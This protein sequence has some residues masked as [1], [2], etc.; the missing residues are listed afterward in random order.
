[1]PFL[2][3][4]SAWLFTWLPSGFTG[5]ELVLND[6]ALEKTR[7][8]GTSI[9]SSYSIR[10]V[11]VYSHDVESWSYQRQCMLIRG[12]TRRQPSGSHQGLCNSK[13]TPLRCCRFQF[14]S[15]TWTSFCAKYKLGAKEMLWRQEIL[16]VWESRMCGRRRWR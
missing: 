9:P 16:L 6:Y 4:V 14:T 13:E 15:S 3:L 10:Q 5:L 7:S 1:V 12:S 8:S 2:K 11:R